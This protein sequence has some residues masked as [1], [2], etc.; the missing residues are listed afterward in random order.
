[1][2]LI[3]QKATDFSRDLELP[4]FTNEEGT[5]A[6]ELLMQKTIE[7]LHEELH[8]TEKALLD[9]DND[10]IVDGFADVAFV[11]LNGIYKQFRICGLNHIQAHTHTVEVMNRVC[12]ANNRKRQADGTVLFVNNKVQKPEGWVGP[13]HSNLFDPEVYE[14]VIDPNEKTV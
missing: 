2:S 7:F 8:E 12:D 6:S 3:I 14:K 11:A 9:K 1:M 5:L 10:K 13:D 4:I